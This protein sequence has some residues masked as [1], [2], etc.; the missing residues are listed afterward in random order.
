MIACASCLAE[1][2]DVYFSSGL[3]VLCPRCHEQHAKEDQ[4]Y[5]RL[6]PQSDHPFDRWRT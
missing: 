2:L 6:A 4:P 3:T 1:N 5:E